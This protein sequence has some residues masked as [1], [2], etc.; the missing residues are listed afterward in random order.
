MTAPSAMPAGGNEP[1]TDSTQRLSGPSVP[2]P[3]TATGPA[4]APV[5]GPPSTAPTTG[6]PS[7]Q[8]PAALSATTATGQ[9][10]GSTNGLHNA[11]ASAQAAAAATAQ[12][13]A[14][15]GRTGIRAT[16]PVTPPRPP[17][18]APPTA[19]A[20]LV[21]R[22]LGVGQIVCV[23]VA[24]L[25]VLLSVL[26]GSPVIIVVTGAVALTVAVPAVLPWRGFW[27]H[28]WLRWKLSY[29]TRRRS[30][31]HADG[32]DPRRAM[33]L[34]L[35]PAA[36]FGE[37]AVDNETVA[38][39]AHPKGMT[40]V[41]ELQPGDHTLFASTGSELPS[42]VSLLSSE[43]DLPPTCAQLIVQVEAPRQLDGARL[44]A[45]SYL[46]LAGG[47]VPVSR[48]VWLAVQVRRTPEAFHDSDLRPA[49]VNAIKRARRR[50]RQDKITARLLGEE[51]LLTAAALAARLESV[52]AHR[53][54][55]Y[56]R[57]QG[58]PVAEETWWRWESGRTPQTA[59]RISRWPTKPWSM[60]KILL[61]LP[62]TA[63]TLS[64]A[65]LR[66]PANP[67]D[68]VPLELVVRIA[69]PDEAGLTASG[70]KLAALISTAGGAVERLD[71]RQLAALIAT[72]PFGGFI[73]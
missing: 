29:R 33:V 48:R 65:A 27:L 14:T 8:S 11:A 37:V 47:L 9:R 4:A 31:P 34:A 52:L 67:V 73:A 63:V 35:Q 59:Y 40:A 15:T 18:A 72:V 43:P 54:G 36:V 3:R 51:E 50:L 69:A 46:Q 16:A 20:A 44:A 30:L 2:Q 23:E 6:A 60:D 38:T 1:A 13:R 19:P 21:R 66:D 56:G 61:G 24:A 39:L 28:T 22:K 12:Q 55:Q 45:E 58:R 49:L 25:A 26:S 17:A 32:A 71:G 53:P 41:L 42:P 10:Q 70:N 7:W 57:P 62:A 64:I 68:E 5:T